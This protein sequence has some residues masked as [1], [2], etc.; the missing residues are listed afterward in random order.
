MRRT[1]LS[2]LLAFAFLVLVTAC[3]S[4]GPGELPAPVAAAGSDVTANPG[5]PV[6]LDGSASAGTEL[7]YSWEF[8]EK[9]DGSSASLDGA[10]T[11]TPS[12][13]PDLPGTYRL[14][15]T[16]RQGNQEDSDTV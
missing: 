7:R 9:P 16:V 13:T 6:R 1:V 15:L 10:G 2:L 4:S 11:A 3:R 14:R 8:T 5:E 12:F